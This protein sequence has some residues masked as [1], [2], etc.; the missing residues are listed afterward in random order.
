LRTADPEKV[1]RDLVGR[2]ER[3]LMGLSDVVTASYLALAERSEDQ[4]KAL[5]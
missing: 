3:D 5:A 1:D 2:V 4:W